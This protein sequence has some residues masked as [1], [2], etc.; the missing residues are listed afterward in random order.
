ME[1]IITRREN[2]FP[3]EERKEYEVSLND[4]NKI[5]LFATTLD[6]KEFSDVSEVLTYAGALS[7]Y[8]YENNDEISSIYKK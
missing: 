5:A 1:T 4:I 8:A 6:T 7:Y 3:N 2:Y